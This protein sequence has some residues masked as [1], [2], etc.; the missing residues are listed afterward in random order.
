MRYT[1]PIKDKARRGFRIVVHSRFDERV[2][3]LLDAPTLCFDAMLQMPSIDLKLYNHTG[4]GIRG[5]HYD[6][7]FLHKPPVRASA[8]AKNIKTWQVGDKNE[9]VETQKDN[10]TIRDQS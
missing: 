4:N 9:K 1:G 5:F 8:D 3:P 2:D 6:P 7:L 10:K